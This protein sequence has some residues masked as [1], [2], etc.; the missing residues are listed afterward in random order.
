[1][2]SI[3]EFTIAPKTATI[4]NVATSPPVIASALEP[5]P[6]SKVER[7]TVVAKS[8]LSAKTSPWAKLIS[9][10]IP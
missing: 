5:L 3:D 7:I 10:R 1:M 8:P 4:R 9:C 2:N 6:R